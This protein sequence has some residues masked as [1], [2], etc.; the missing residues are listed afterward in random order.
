MNKAETGERILPDGRM[1]VGAA[2][3]YLG[4][5]VSTLAIHR[6]RGTGPKFLKLG[7]VWYF[8]EDLDD[9]VAAAGRHSSTGAARAQ[10]A[11]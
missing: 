8:R 1:S 9:W 3:A 6:C 2:A 11:A 4:L 10:R 5:A 7:R